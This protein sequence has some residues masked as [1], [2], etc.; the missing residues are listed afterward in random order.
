MDWGRASAMVRTDPGEE[1]S[2]RVLP[3]TTDGE[4]GLD[5]IP[6]AVPTPDDVLLGAEG[7]EVWY[8]RR[9]DTLAEPGTTFRRTPTDRV[10]TAA[11]LVRWHAGAPT[12]ERCHASTV[13]DSHGQ[14]RRCT[15]CG[16]ML[17]FRTDPAVIVGIT[18]AHDRLLLAR[19]ATWPEGRVSVIAGFVEV[20]ES[21]EQAC[22]REAMEEVAVALTDIRY[23]GS[24]PWPFPRSLM[25]GFTARAE[26]PETLRPD[27]QEIVEASFLT[28]E[29][30]ASDVAR[31]RRTL[32]GVASIGRAI[33]D[34][35][36]AG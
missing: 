8:A 20:G 36:L 22:A 27:G 23:F 17:F 33:V 5:P 4:V 34:A 28:R 11:A 32:P 31:G 21:L 30:L 24:Q 16:A 26:Q 10:A 25:V 18:D 3:V 29:E 7:D 9:V 1:A 12:C 15:R 6:D 14:R 13:P 2:A 35:W 19:H